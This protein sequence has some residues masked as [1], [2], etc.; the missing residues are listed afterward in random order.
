V[1]RLE[2]WVDVVALHRQGL[3]IKAISRRLGI[4]RNTVRAAL[5]RE[6]PP[7]YARPAKP[8]KLDPFKDYL[9]ARL[10]EFPE[11]SAVVLL[12]EVCALGYEGG[13]SILKDFTRPYRI[14]R[15]EPVVRFETPPGRQ[16]Q[17]DWAH[18]GT[19]EIA[20][21]ETRL[22]LFVMVLGFSRALF[23]EVVEQTEMQT[24]LALHVRA[25]QAFGGMP[26]EILYDNQKVVVLSR[27]PEGPHFH[28]ELLA[29][30]GHFGFRPRL[31]RPYRARTKGKVERSIGYLRDRFF[32]GRTFGSVEDLNHELAH[33]LR[34]VANER[35][36]QTTGEQPSVRLRRERLLPFAV[37][38]PWPL[39]APPAPSGDRPRFRFS[40][41]EVER[42]SLAVY[43]EVAR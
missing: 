18:L 26:E 21:R 4:S 23:A 39:L 11:L 22:F 3:S 16:A 20:G 29:F 5:R 9:L 19:H 14:R 6:G 31:C 38:R 13:L 25:F 42:R 8:S 17:C 40:A 15:R 27:T 43:E 30:A 1:I 10:A 12:E 7:V 41:P 34:T 28:P 2:E 36:H 37:A 32:T 24:F 33:W 35:E